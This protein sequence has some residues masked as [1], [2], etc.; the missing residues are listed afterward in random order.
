MTRRCDLGQNRRLRAVCGTDLLLPFINAGKAVFQVEY[1][2]A[3]LANTICPQAN[4]LNFDTLIKNWDLD[5]WRVA[6]R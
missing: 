5:A 3:S 4:S 1:R 2:P 6:C